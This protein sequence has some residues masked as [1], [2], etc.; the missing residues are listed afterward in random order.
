MPILAIVVPVSLPALFVV[1]AVSCQCHLPP[2]DKFYFIP[3]D[4]DISQVNLNG[5]ACLNMTYI[6]SILVFFLFFF[7]SFFFFFFVVG[8]LSYGGCM[9][10]F[11]LQER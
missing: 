8:L 11:F 6:P 4:V 10:R 7:F 5:N 2:L 9:K 3:Q 1:V